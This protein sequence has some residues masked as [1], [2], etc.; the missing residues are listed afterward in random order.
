MTTI[1]ILWIALTI[2]AIVMTCGFVFKI[3]WLFM[4]AGLLWFIPITLIDNL[5][6]V[7]VSSVMVL[8][9][10]VLTFLQR[11]KGEFLFIILIFLF[12]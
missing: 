6:I 3:Q 5:F 12:F 8:A 4:V 10:A 9:H 11:E 1:E 7:S 2:Y